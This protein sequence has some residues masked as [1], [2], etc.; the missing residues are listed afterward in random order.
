M[1]ACRNAYHWVN[2]RCGM[3]P[4]LDS[5]HEE[6]LRE[7]AKVFATEHK[8]SSVM[9][10]PLM[11]F[12]LKWHSMWTAAVPDFI[13]QYH[14]VENDDDFVYLLSFQNKEENCEE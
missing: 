10:N 13:A 3:R 1:R 7:T 6:E 12:P 4:A 11:P 14:Q 2:I 8:I 9:L 5:N